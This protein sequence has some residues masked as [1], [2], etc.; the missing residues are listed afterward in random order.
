[1]QWLMW[2][3]EGSIE[4]EK[5]AAVVSWMD[6]E[7]HFRS[8]YKAT[9]LGGLL[10]L[11][12]GPEQRSSWR[13]DTEDGCAKRRRKAFKQRIRATTTAKPSSKQIESQELSRGENERKPC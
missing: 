7:A 9:D 11:D 6:S 12:Y 8:I 10:Q 4:E 2:T 5:E 13:A 3:Q 1:M